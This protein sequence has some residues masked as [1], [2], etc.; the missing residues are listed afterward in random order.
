ME[1]ERWKAEELEYRTRMP[2]TGIERRG[3]EMEEIAF[4]SEDQVKGCRWLDHKR[5]KGWHRSL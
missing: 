1:V 3:P 4:E 5:L 2:E